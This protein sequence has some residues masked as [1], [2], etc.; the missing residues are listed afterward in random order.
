LPT[1]HKLTHWIKGKKMHKKKKNNHA[2]EERKEVEE[3]EHTAQRKNCAEPD[4][5]P[6]LIWPA[7]ETHG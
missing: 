1:T 6:T 7:T 3:K 2:V 4:P 5:R